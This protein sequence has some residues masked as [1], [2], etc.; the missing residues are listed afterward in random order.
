MRLTIDILYALLAEQYGVER[1]GKASASGDLPLPIFFHRS[2]KPREG[3]LYIARSSDLPERLEKRSV[4]I[5]CGSRPTHA[6]RGSR[7]DILYV[8]DDSLDIVSLFNFVQGVFQ[9][10]GNWLMKMQAILDEKAGVASMV[11]ASIPIFENRIAVTDYSMR[12][13]AECEAVERNGERAVEMT[14]HFDRVPVEISKFLKS[15]QLCGNRGHAPFTVRAPRGGS[16]VLVDNYCI[17]LFIGNVYAGVCT[18][19]ED[20]KPLRPSDKM[21]FQTFAQYLEKALLSRQMPDNGG[22]IPLKGILNDLLEN[23]PVA[24]SDLNQ[25]LDM[26]FSSMQ[27]GGTKQG[28]WHMAA[29]KSANRDKTLP[30]DYICGSLEE[31]LPNSFAIGRE[32]HIALLLFVEEGADI[33]EHARTRLQPYLSDMHFMAGVSSGFANLFK[34]RRYYQQALVLLETGAQF[35]RDASLFLFKDEI[36]RYMLKNSVG[37]LDR[38]Q[39]LTDGLRALRERGGSVDYWETLKCY[40]DTECNASQTS[41]N[42]YLHRSTLLPRLETIQQYVSLDTPED[43][44]YLRM[45]LHLF[46]EK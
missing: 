2:M 27:S 35:H 15:E 6:A 40:L 17:N 21:L 37:I 13:I 38:E 14:D 29:I 11:R 16:E 9:R 26:V 5:C 12:V 10:I 24:E 33:R 7:A 36:L 32:D 25:A 46:D 39:V 31:L 44:L 4:F 28:Q 23:F 45:C 22:I 34:A 3:A 8:A 30:M 1:M 18:L 42:L 41:Q 43:R 19:C 20:L